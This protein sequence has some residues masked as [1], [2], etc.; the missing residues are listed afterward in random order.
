MI[1]T[2]PRQICRKQKKEPPARK[3]LKSMAYSLLTLFKRQRPFFKTRVACWEFRGSASK[4]RFI[5][6]EGHRLFDLFPHPV[7][8]P[9]LIDKWPRALSPFDF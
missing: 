7:F 3:V 8:F 6:A 1:K 5:S 4:A 2:R 9:H